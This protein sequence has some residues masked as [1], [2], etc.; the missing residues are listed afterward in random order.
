MSCLAMQSCVIV[1]TAAAAAAIKTSWEIG[2]ARVCYLLQDTVWFGVERVSAG[3][4][5]SESAHQAEPTYATPADAVDYGESVRVEAGILTLSGPRGDMSTT[6]ERSQ[7][8]QVQTRAV[9]LVDT[10]NPLLRKVKVESDGRRVGRLWFIVIFRHDESPASVTCYPSRFLAAP[11]CSRA[12][13]LLCLL[14][15]ATPS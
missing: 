2:H 13:S 14:A 5:C 4:R 9:F 7:S 1:A 3:G 11:S 6:T 10:R 15:E 12:P 8:L